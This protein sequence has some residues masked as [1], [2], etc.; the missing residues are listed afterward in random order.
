MR[1]RVA[2]LRRLGQDHVEAALAL[3]RRALRVSV[4]RAFEGRTDPGF[5][6]CVPVSAQLDEEQVFRGDE[7]AR[8]DACE[9]K[10]IE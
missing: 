9:A 10:V 3:G 2:I 7:L 5:E 1:L 4:N 6:D 8:C